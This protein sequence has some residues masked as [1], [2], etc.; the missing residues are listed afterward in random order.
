MEKVK[1]TSLVFLFGIGVI[2][3]CLLALYFVSAFWYIFDPTLQFRG[4]IA[5]TPKWILFLSIFALLGYTKRIK[6]F[7]W[8]L[9]I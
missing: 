5:Y 9:K 8:N 3:S 2:S 6:N 1:I 4:A 7:L